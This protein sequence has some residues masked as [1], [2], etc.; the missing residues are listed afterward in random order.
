MKNLKN[1]W[2]KN[3]SLIEKDGSVIVSTG[4]MHELE[5]ISELFSLQKFTRDK[6]NFITPFSLI[7]KE[8]WYDAIWDE[9]ILALEAHNEIAF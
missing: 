6:I 2:E 4:R 9:P 8:K 5:N 7:K 3:Y 1:I